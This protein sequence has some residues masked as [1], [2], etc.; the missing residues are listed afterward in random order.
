MAVW[1]KRLG[2]ER[3]RLLGLGEVS[4]SELDVL[5]ARP[6]DAVLLM[7]FGQ[8]SPGGR[9]VAVAE[10]GLVASYR[11]ALPDL[12]EDDVIGSPYCMHDYVVDERFGGPEGLVAARGQLADRGLALILDSVGAKPRRARPSVGHGSPAAAF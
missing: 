6:V 3:G 7:G 4:G 8:R 2:R 10:P 11:A 1:L 12:R 5:V 9:A